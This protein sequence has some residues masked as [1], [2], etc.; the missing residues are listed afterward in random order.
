[1]CRV[2]APNVLEMK[3][4]LFLFQCFFRRTSDCSIL[5][6]CDNTTV[7]AYINNQGGSCSARV[8]NL[9]LS[10]WRFCIQR[11]IMIRAVHVAGSDNSEA[12]TLSR[13]PS[14]DHSYFLSQAVFASI[15]SGL[16]FSLSV[17]CFA[18]RLNY[19]LPIF[20]SWHSDPLS[21]LVDAFSV[22]WSGGFTSFLPCL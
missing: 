6:R 9:A 18:S 12:D 10:L 8:C 1:M 20:Y 11:N 21:S 7:V 5:I 15:S 2:W 17:D 13:M 19:R 22:R 16:P 14:N 4:V 3:A